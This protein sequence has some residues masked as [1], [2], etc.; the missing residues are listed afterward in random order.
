[1]KKVE[2]T[3]KERAGRMYRRLLLLQRL[4]HASDEDD[5]GTEPGTDDRTRALAF[6]AAVREVLDELTEHARLVT[7]LP[8]PISEWRPGDGPDDERWRALTE[9][10]RREV[11]SLVSGYENLISWAEDEV[12]RGQLQVASLV[13]VSGDSAT[14]S[15]PGH[16]LQRSNDAASYLKAERARIKRFRQDMGFLRKQ[17]A[18]E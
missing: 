6:G 7:S 4:F 15:S 8:F 2:P 5:N 17:P 9:V 3:L 16:A 10:E 13:T 14:L 12:T 11:A 1:M 18:A